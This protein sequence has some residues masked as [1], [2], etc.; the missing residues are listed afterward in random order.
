MGIAIYAI[1]IIPLF[2][3]LA[4]ESVK[5]SWFADD[6]SVGD[7]LVGIHRWWMKLVSVAPTCMY[8]YIPS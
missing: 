5:Q 1:G 4:D 8:G 3:H 6:A 7:N 2:H